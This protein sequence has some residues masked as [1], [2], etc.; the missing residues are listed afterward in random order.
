MHV[1]YGMLFNVNTLIL[2]YK[3]IYNIGVLK[4]NIKLMW[5]GLEMGK[6]RDFEVPIP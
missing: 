2:K 1:V 3:Y 4:V 5:R 6:R